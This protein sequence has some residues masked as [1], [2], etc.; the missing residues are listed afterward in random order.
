MAALRANPNTGAILMDATDQTVYSFN[1]T[2]LARPKSFDEWQ[3]VGETPCLFDWQAD[4]GRY[5]PHYVTV[6]IRLNRDRAAW[7]GGGS[8]VFIQNYL[9]DNK[10]QIVAHLFSQCWIDRNTARNN[11]QVQW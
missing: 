11:A 7:S 1:G 5:G 4:P 6:Q 10:D 3:Q 8:F 9:R 2:P